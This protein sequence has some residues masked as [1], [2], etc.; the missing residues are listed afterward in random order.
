MK[1]QFKRHGL[2]ALLVAG[3]LALA[4]GPGAAGEITGNGKS[5]K[6]PDGTLNGNSACAFSGRQDTPDTAIAEGHKGVM[7]QSWGQLVKPLR[8]FLTSIGVNPGNA[9][10][11]TRAT[12]E[13]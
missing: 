9:C 5:L 8:D 2:T 3:A 4:A 12:G 1:T 10:N 11:P 7:A 6:N 13:P